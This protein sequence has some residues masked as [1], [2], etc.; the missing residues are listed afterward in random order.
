M[1]EIEQSRKEQM[2]KD[3]MAF[4]INET[5]SMPKGFP[6]PLNKRLFVKRI[7]DAG[8][9]T[10]KV[11][12]GGQKII[13]ASSTNTIIPDTAVIYAVGPEVTEFLYPGLTVMLNPHAQIEVMYAGEVYIH[14]HEVDVNGILPP[15]TYVHAGTKSQKQMLT[16]KHLK[17]LEGYEE[18]KEKADLNAL[19]KQ[20]ERLKKLKK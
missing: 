11:L 14:C 18:R 4:P 2:L 17:D 3:V 15:K 6:I 16:E 20:M 12:E 13:L 8:G 5:F 9:M 7:S 10:E 19:D 1:T